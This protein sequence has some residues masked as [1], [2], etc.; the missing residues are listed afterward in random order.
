MKQLVIRDLS[1]LTIQPAKTAEWST[2]CPKN[3]KPSCETS[4][5]WHQWW[6]LIACLRLLYGHFGAWFML[7]SI[8][9]LV[10]SSGCI[11]SAGFFWDTRGAHGL[12]YVLTGSPRLRRTALATFDT[13]VSGTKVYINICQNKSPWELASETRG[14][15]LLPR[16]QS[17]NH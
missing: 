3:N 15:E 10:N 11:C 16:T 13:F 4:I 17:G 2:P 14:R 8:I 6:L 12:R 5:G 1:G 7:H 9:G